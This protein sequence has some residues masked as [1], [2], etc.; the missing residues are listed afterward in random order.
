MSLLGAKRFHLIPAFKLIDCLPLLHAMR[1]PWAMHTDFQKLSCG[2]G[3]SKLHFLLSVAYKIREKNRIP[4]E[5]VLQLLSPIMCWKYPLAI[6]LTVSTFCHLSNTLF[7]RTLEF[8][9][10]APDTR[11]EE[12]TEA[13]GFLRTLPLFLSLICDITKG[14]LWRFSK[15]NH[16]TICFLMRIHRA[17]IPLRLSGAAAVGGSS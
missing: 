11:H 10:N 13:P 14:F 6:K 1:K 16:V 4:F 9:Q 2:Q 17:L 3:I 8:Q 7:L 12:G 5:M 15:T